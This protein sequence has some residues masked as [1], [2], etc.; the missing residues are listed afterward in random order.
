MVEQSVS[1]RRQKVSR[2][3]G[4]KP[5]HVLLVPLA[6]PAITAD[7]LCLPTSCLTMDV[8]STKKRRQTVARWIARLLGCSPKRS[9]PHLLKKDRE[10]VQLHSVGYP[11][12]LK[13]LEKLC[14]EIRARGV[15]REVH[16]SRQEDDERQRQY[17]GP[18]LA[19]ERRLEVGMGREVAEQRVAV[20]GRFGSERRKKSM[21]RELANIERIIVCLRFCGIRVVWPW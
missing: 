15:G 5:C 9:S 13:I 10:G 1:G 20:S 19:K 18:C 4:G 7:L 2:G 8:L 11:M 12:F 3:E 6:D 14:R 21:V 17:R 16:F